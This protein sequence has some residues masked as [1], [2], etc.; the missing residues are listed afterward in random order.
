MLTLYAWASPTPFADS[1]V[2]HTWVTDYDDRVNLYANIAAIIAAQAHYWFCWGDFHAEA[3]RWLG[4]AD[5]SVPW[6]SCLCAP[7]AP[8]ASNQPT[9]GTIYHYGIDGVCHQLANQA[10]WSTSGGGAK[11]LKVSK[12]NGY[13][14]ST[15]FYGTYG[16]QH[17]AWAARKTLCLPPAIAGAAGQGVQGGGMSVPETDDDEFIAR[18]QAA[19]SKH[20][21]QHKLP[22]LLTLRAQSHAALAVHKAGLA[23]GVAPTAETLNKQHRM[24]LEEAGR[25]LTDAEFE[26]VFGIRKNQIAQ[27]QLVNPEIFYRR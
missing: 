26:D 6:S 1:P 10:L 21:A 27:V 12:A 9:C 17:G 16:L 24:H 15:F 20:Q 4:S 7:N 25:L 23:K 11:P 8:S 2:D 22:A 19:L 18:A 13:G 3:R 5:G 14:L